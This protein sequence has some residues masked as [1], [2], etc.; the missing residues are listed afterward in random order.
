MR[1]TRSG[2]VE[3][4]Q[5]WGR[6]QSAREEF[7]RLRLAVAM[8]CVLALTAD[9]LF[10]SRVQG[11]LAAAGQEVELLADAAA[12]ARAARRAPRRRARSCWSSI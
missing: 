10:G 1:E 11:S 7:R 12:A 2:R 8:A 6:P 3:V 9:L 4:T 5:M